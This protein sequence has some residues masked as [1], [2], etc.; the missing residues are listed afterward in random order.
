MWE[1][2]SS[3]ALLAAGPVRYDGREL[4]SAGAYNEA[5]RSHSFPPLSSS[6]ALQYQPSSMIANGRPSCCYVAVV[7][8]AAAFT[9]G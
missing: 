9:A 2:R 4:V 8:I 3:L 1:V 5:V 7:I 6:S